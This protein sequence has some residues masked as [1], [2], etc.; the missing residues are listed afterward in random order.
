MLCHFKFFSLVFNKLISS[1]IVLCYL[2]ISYYGN[3]LSQ[4]AMQNT[5]IYDF[6]RTKLI[7]KKQHKNIKKTNHTCTHTQTIPIQ[8][9][10][11][12]QKHTK[13]PH[14]TPNKQN[15]TNDIQPNNNRQTQ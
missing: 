11:Q 5:L 8:K 10:K 15:Q 7:K 9:T 14:K 12:Q 2:Q 3:G 13:N 4:I 1:L 6:M